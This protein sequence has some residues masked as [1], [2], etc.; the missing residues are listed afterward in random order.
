MT[1]SSGDIDP[2]E[3]LLAEL[4]PKVIEPIADIATPDSE[5]TS[6]ILRLS[7]RESSFRVL[8][9]TVVELGD[10][11]L[12]VVIL[13]AAPV[14]RMYYSEA[15]ADGQS[16]QP[17]CWSTDAGGGLPATQVSTGNRQASAC[18]DCPQN[19]KGSGNGFSRACR[20]QQRLA[21][22][23]ADKDGVL[24]PNQVC[25]LSLPATS[26]FGKDT[27]KKGLQTYAKLIDSQRAL[28]STIMTELSFDADN[29][30]PKICFRPFR[31]LSEDEFT[32]VK[33]VQN[34][35]KTK[36]LVTFNPKPY[37]DDGPSMDNV[38]ST[39]KGDGVYVTSL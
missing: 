33:E 22:M 26:V 12:K 23:L 32:V 8:G 16:K 13:K 28:L 7:I 15:Y 25:Q 18:F 9:D 36:S 31:V 11:P 24:Q 6:A 14:S 37:I 17:T 39:V 20:Y 19:I 38:F 10:E 21:V 2:F 27:K 35:P 30:A 34:D 5:E 3:S 1:D 4:K 29:S